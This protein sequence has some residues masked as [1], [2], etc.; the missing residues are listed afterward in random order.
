MTPFV[1]PPATAVVADPTQT[2]S[3]NAPRTAAMQT[4]GRNGV[5]VLRDEKGRLLPGQTPNPLGRQKGLS[6]R[7]REMV[8]F[9]KAI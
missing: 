2:P 8:D 6:A 5:T 7:V 4:T 9:D 1:Q 3:T